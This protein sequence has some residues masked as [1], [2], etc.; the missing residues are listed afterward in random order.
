MNFN[1]FQRILKGLEEFYNIIFPIC[2]KKLSTKLYV[3]ELCP[4][5]LETNFFPQNLHNFTPNCN[6]YRLLTDSD[7]VYRLLFRCAETFVEG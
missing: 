1:I 7:T 2:E 3:F 6:S 5:F 4:E